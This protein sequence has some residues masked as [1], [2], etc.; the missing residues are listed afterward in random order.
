VRRTD[1]IVCVVSGKERPNDPEEIVRQGV[2]RKLLEDYG[3]ERARI[4]VEL[5]VKMGSGYPKFADIAIFQDGHRHEQHGANIIVECK[6]GTSKR[7][8]QDAVEQLKSYMAACANAQ[9]G[10]ATN[11]TDSLYVRKVKAP[12]GMISYPDWNDIPRADEAPGPLSMGRPPGG[13]ERRRPWMSRVIVV[14]LVALVG[15]VVARMSAHVANDGTDP[16]RSILAAPSVPN[17][18]GG[19][20]SAA[21]NGAT[22]TSKGAHTRQTA[23]A[24]G[25]SPSTPP[26]TP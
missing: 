11:G 23:P 19:G 24:R 21:P 25:A 18:T 3:Y 8:L 20:T 17:A 13:P 16:G 1:H 9:Y 22:P 12:N 26:P 7:K 10:V 4:C 2:L 6:A 5:P 15:L 14:G